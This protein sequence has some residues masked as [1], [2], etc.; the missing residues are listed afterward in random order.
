MHNYH[1]ELGINL[2]ELLGTESIEN[3]DSLP[4][5]YQALVN[6]TDE[7]AFIDLWQ[8]DDCLGPTLTKKDLTSKEMK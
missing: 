1:W 6:C 5:A 7:S 3:F 8:G 4:K 2:G